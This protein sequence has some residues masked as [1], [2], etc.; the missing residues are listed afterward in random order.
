VYLNKLLKV[1]EGIITGLSYKNGD[2]Y[3]NIIN[4]Q[5]KFTG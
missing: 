4:I 3:N 1:E 2:K 5:Y